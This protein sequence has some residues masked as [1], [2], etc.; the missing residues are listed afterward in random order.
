ML[1]LARGY[2]FAGLHCCIRPDRDRRRAGQCRTPGAQRQHDRVRLHSG[3]KQSQ[4]GG[5]PHRWARPQPA[6]T[7]SVCPSGCV[8]HAVR[9][10]GSNV[11][12]APATRAGSGAVK[13]GSIRTMPVNQSAD[14]RPDGSD[15][16]RLMSIDSLP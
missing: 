3:L 16:A 13:S 2:R 11:T 5:P 12:L 7:I 9:A 15:P 6:V 4:P 10:P 14:P 1:H 8:C